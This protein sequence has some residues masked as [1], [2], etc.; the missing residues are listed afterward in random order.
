MKKLDF[1]TWET[2]RRE[3][4]SV[5]M[6]FISMDNIESM[7]LANLDIVEFSAEHNSESPDQTFVEAFDEFIIGL[8][9]TAKLFILNA[10]MSNIFEMKMTHPTNV[11]K[12]NRMRDTD[13]SINQKLNAVEERAKENIKRELNERVKERIDRNRRN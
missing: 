7:F 8:S 4:G 2:I 9:P 11:F 1:Q 5:T 13:P 3:M 10:V 12:I 6:N